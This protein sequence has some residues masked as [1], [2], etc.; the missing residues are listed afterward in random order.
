MAID[1]DSIRHSTEQSLQTVVRQ[2]SPYCNE[3]KELAG[4]LGDYTLTL[5]N[6]IPGRV[7][8][9][10]AAII[11]VVCVTLVA[12]QIC[13]LIAPYFSKLIQIIT[14]L[15]QDLSDSISNTCFT[16]VIAGSC[17]A[18]YRWAKPTVDPKVACALTIATLFLRTMN[19]LFK[20]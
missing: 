20:N 16:L 18:F 9:P 11:S 17:V 19:K 6:S 15:H 12:H 5:I 10:K 2:M 1:F 14:K 3:A 7:K 4:Q 8:D 13:A